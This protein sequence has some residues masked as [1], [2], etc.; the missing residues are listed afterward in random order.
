MHPQAVR[1]LAFWWDTE[2]EMEWLWNHFLCCGIHSVDKQS[3]SPPNTQTLQTVN[4]RGE[5]PEVGKERIFH[6]SCQRWDFTETATCPAH[7]P[8]TFEETSLKSRCCNERGNPLGLGLSCSVLGRRQQVPLL[9]SVFQIKGAQIP[10]KA[11]PCIIKWH[12]TL[13][14]IHDALVKGSRKLTLPVYTMRQTFM[15]FNSGQTHC[16]ANLN[17]PKNPYVPDSKR[18]NEEQISYLD[19]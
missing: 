8:L 10:H 6:G 13:L 17:Y 12:V 1:P 5:S 4:L 2:R 14:G 11:V 3:Q 16:C 7:L 9:L 18:S 19:V 15:G